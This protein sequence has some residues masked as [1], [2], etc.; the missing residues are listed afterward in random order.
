MNILFR[1]KERMPLASH[2]M[3]VDGKKCLDVADDAQRIDIVSVY[4]QRVPVDVDELL[5]GTNFE[6]SSARV[7]DKMSKHTFSLKKISVG[8]IERL[9]DDHAIQNML[10]RPYVVNDIKNYHLTVA[11]MYKCLQG[12]TS[13]CATCQSYHTYKENQRLVVCSNCSVRVPQVDYADHLDMHARKKQKSNVRVWQ[14]EKKK[15]LLQ[16]DVVFLGESLTDEIDYC[17]ICHETFT[18][19]FDKVCFSSFFLFFL[20]KLF[21]L[22][23]GLFTVVLRRLSSS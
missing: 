12:I 19:A 3:Y 20:Y 23:S 11:R 14:Q 7:S 18:C 21:L 1:L 4:A 15:E 9:F 2:T 8:D 5:A 6:L 16:R 22:C 10:K 17:N 13:P